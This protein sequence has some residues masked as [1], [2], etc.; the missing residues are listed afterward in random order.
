M[1][2]EGFLKW[3]S[4]LTILIGI[5]IVASVYLILYRRK[6]AKHKRIKH[7]ANLQNKNDQ[8]HNISKPRLKKTL[9]LKKDKIKH[10]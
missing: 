1:Y 8:V 10:K 7:E 4:I 9:V 3:E 6:K 2:E 5:V